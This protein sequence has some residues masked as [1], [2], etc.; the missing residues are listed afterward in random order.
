MELSDK[1]WALFPFF[2]HFPFSL[3]RS[4]RI[5]RWKPPEPNIPRICLRNEGNTFSFIVFI[6]YHI[7]NNNN[8]NIVGHPYQLFFV[9]ESENFAIVPLLLRS[10]RTGSRLMVNRMKLEETI[11]EVRSDTTM[12]IDRWTWVQGWQT[13]RTIWPLIPPEILPGWL[14]PN[15]FIRWSEW[16]EASGIERPSTILKL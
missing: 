8:G 5:W 6:P 2:D 3:I 1:I 12:Q 7:D 11:V 14:Q 4:W 10:R 9:L 15:R 16:W 13:N